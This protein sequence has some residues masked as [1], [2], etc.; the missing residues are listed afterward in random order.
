MSRAWDKAKQIGKIGLAVGAVVALFTPGLSL[1]W[2]ALSYGLGGMAI[3]GLFGAVTKGSK[4]KEEHHVSHSMA[5]P[6]RQYADMTPE[7]GVSTFRDQEKARRRTVSQG[8]TY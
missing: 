4:P 5:P 1:V 8:R 6:M 2:G 7:Q 3:G